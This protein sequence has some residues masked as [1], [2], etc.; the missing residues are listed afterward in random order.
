MR[1][2]PKDSVL[3]NTPDKTDQRSG[4]QRYPCDGRE[5][6]GNVSKLDGRSRCEGE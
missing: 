6:Q 3:R 4:F 1:M 2:Q 5:A